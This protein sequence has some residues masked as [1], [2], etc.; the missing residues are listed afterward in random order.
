MMNIFEQLLQS[1]RFM[2]H[3]GEIMIS[4]EGVTRELKKLRRLV[5]RK[6]HIKIELWVRLSVLRLFHVC[7]VVQN[8][9]CLLPLAGHKWL[10][11][12]ERDQRCGQAGPQI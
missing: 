10:Y 11:K 5:Q 12:A 3:V 6:R 1:S 9:Q 4:V 8:S 2:T 7:H